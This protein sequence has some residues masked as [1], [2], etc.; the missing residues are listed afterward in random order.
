MTID[1][2]QATI[3]RHRTCSRAQV[4][5]WLGQLNIKPIGARQ[6]PQRY[7]ETAAIAILTHLGFDSR[8]DTMPAAK[9]IPAM[10]ELRTERKK[11]GVR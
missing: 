6:R 9:G 3:H 11:A 5:N 8:R 7:P 10:R 1:K 4:Y 2:I